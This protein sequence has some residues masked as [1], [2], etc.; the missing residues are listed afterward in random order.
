M[1]SMDTESGLAEP[2]AAG[3]IFGTFYI[4]VTTR[5]VDRKSHTGTE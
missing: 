3:P 4:F 2:A 5:T 1:L